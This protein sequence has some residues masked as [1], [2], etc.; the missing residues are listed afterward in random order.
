M[1]APVGA[2]GAIGVL[3]F[4]LFLIAVAIALDPL[5]LTAYVLVLASKR[6]VRKGAAFLFGW[7][8][9]LAAVVAITLATPA[10]TR[11]SRT[12]RRRSPAWPSRSPSASAWS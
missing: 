2:P 7:L 6:G 4:E 9:S 5:P 10:T 1:S 3:V 12:R 11:R 8:V